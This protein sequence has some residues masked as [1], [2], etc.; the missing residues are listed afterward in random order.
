M[1]DTDRAHW[2][3]RYRGADPVLL[4]QIGPPARFAP[5][6]HLFPTSGRAL[7]LACGTGRTAAWLAARGLDVTA[8]DVS[9]VAIAHAE[10]LVRR[11]GLAARCHFVVAD[12][13]DGLPPGPPVD[14]VVCNLFRDARLDDAIVER[15]A[16]GGLLAI[17]VLSE[18]GAAP[19]RF[20]ARPGELLDAFGALDVIDAGE[21][22]G[23][24][25]LLGRRP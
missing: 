12:L 18:V 10:D 1:A 4:D 20:R 15:L 5:H 21:E 2:D 7:E 9:S 24:A 8:V 14:V 25:W 16:P 23:V 22:D 11:A 13:D 3:D 19:G 6:E 17:A